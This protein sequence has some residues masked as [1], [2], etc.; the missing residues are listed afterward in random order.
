MNG[1][2]NQ[3]YS[4]QLKKFS[5]QLGLRL[6][7]SE[8][9]GNFIS[10]NQEFSN[11]Y[12]FSLFPSTYL[13]YKLTERQ[14]L[15]LNYS[16]KINRPNFF[17]LIPFIDYTDSLNLSIG[18]PDLKPEFT[19]L[20][21][22]GYANQY[23]QGSF[24]ASIYARNTEDL[25]TRYTYRT[26]NPDTLKNNQVLFTTFA[27]ATRSYTFGLELTGKNKPAKWWD[28]TTNLNFF[29]TTIEASNL[30]GTNNNSRFSWFG[31]VNNSFKLPKKFSVQLTGDY[32]AKTLLPASS[33]GRGGGGGG[34]HGM[35]GGGG[36][37]FGQVQTTPQ[38]F[39]KPVYGADFSIRKEFMKN[40]AA[41]LTL[42]VNDIF[43]SRVSA[44]HSES[45]FFVQDNERRRDPQVARLNFNWR[46]GKFDVALFKR[47]NMRS[48][49]DMQSI[50]QSPGQ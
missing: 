29:K 50:Q 6:E 18:N 7:S 17:Q 24:F 4:K 47:K 25:I 35:F 19:N 33:G 22:I 37:G 5:Y 41:S 12:P 32:Q 13:T 28:I 38:G 2:Q 39:I 11:K 27:N 30:A 42:Q 20:V 10:K 40:N 15:Q 48:D 16:R 9:N 14:D 1:N 3:C 43:R 21:E 8:Y 45:M 31:K 36:G 49:M 23:K 44:S 34:A 26:A 46:F